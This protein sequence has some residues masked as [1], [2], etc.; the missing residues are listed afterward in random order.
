MDRGDRRDVGSLVEGP[1]VVV[2]REGSLLSAAHQ[3]A[4]ADVSAAVVGHTRWLEGVITEHHIADAVA[5][6]LDLDATPV[7]S[8]MTP[9][10]SSVDAT[11]PI[12]AAKRRVRDIT[13]HFLAVTRHGQVVGLLTAEQVLRVP[14]RVRE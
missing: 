2:G 11:T 6:G 12:D 4:A 9:Y 1:L 10:L 5:R 13:G 7:G 8:F 3:M 14:S